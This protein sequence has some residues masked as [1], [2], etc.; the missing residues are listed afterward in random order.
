LLF[1]STDESC[2]QLGGILSYG[3][4][5]LPKY[6]ELPLLD[7]AERVTQEKQARKTQEEKNGTITQWFD[8]SED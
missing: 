6:E 3:S 5:S 7:N 4:K 2:G 1:N 8:F